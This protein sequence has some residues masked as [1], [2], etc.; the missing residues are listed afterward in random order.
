MDEIGK[1]FASMAMM[2]L[3]AFLVILSLSLGFYDM[4]P[5]FSFGLAL[6]GFGGFIFYLRHISIKSQSR[7]KKAKVTRVVREVPKP[8]PKPEPTPQIEEPKR[9]EIICD[10]CQFYMEYNPKQ[11]CKFLSD[12]DRLAMIN[13]GIECVEYKIRL[14]MLDED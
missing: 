4:I 8:K 12:K 5:W 6:C 14:T 13:A 2:V 11:K 9:P 10:T 3:G 1:W 7:V